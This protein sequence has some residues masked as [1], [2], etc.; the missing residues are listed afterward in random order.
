MDWTPIIAA[1][2]GSGALSWIARGL[3]DRWKSVQEALHEERR[4]RYAQVLNP[5]VQVFATL[6]LPAS[7]KKKRQ[8][9]IEQIIQSAEYR[10]ELFDLALVANDGV[11]QTYNRMMKF[12]RMAEDSTDTK[13]LQRKGMAAFGELLVEIRKSVGNRW[14][15][16]D[17]VDMLEVIGVR[18]AA[19]YL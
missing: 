15:R 12:Y 1:A 2:L 3:M 7:K 17:K 4:E 8:Q 16:L 9:E 11:V 5:Y 14:T 10:K 18:D 6:D 19:E 13:E